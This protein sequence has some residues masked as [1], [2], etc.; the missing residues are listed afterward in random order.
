MNV[1]IILLR[2]FIGSWMIPASWIL[3][4]P[5]IALLVGTKSATEETISLDHAL[6]NGLY[7]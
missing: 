2:I 4:W 5:L 6:W 1:R 7:A 3:V